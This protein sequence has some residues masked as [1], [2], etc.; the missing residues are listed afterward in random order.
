M[1]AGEGKKARNFGLPHPSPPHPVRGWS[2]SA[3]STS[4]S[5]PKSKLAEVEQMVFALFLLLLLFLFSSLSFSLCFF[6]LSFS[7]SSF[8]SYSYFLFVLFLFLSPKTFVLNP[9]PQPLNPPL[10]NPPLDL[11]SAGPPKISLFFFPLP[12]QFSFFFHSLGVL[13]WNFVGVFEGRALK[14]AHLGSRVVVCNPNNPTDRAAGART[15]QPENS[16]LSGPRAP[17]T[18]ANFDPGHRLFLFGQF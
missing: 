2:T 9:E 1:G 10:D 8:S 3:I 5:W 16:K 15:R 7:P 11:P 17:S 13:P 12:P 14:C 4:A 6:S 18:Q